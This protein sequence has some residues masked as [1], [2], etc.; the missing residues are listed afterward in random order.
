MKAFKVLQSGI[1]FTSHFSVRDLM[2]GDEVIMKS[3]AV[4]G[5]ARI[6]KVTR[7]MNTQI[8]IECTNVIPTKDK[9]RIGTLNP[10]VDD[11]KKGGFFEH[12]AWWR[13]CAIGDKSKFFR[14][15]GIEVGSSN[16]WNP[17]GLAVII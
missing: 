17:R 1:D 14:A 16:E 4:S 2:V 15:N 9:C 10:F 13:K 12:W 6:G 11:R 3:M 5:W 8:E 7:V